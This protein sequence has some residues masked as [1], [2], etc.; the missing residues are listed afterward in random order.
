MWQHIEVDVRPR[1]GETARRHGL[2]LE[3]DV[4]AAVCSRVG[5]ARA[6]SMFGTLTLPELA[7]LL[8]RS[9]LLIGNDSGITHLAAA[10]GTPTVAL[11]GPQD[12]RRFRPWSD[13][14]IALR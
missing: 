5:K 14:A 7:A 11:F 10:C 9:S 2:A 3:R 1:G 4:E 8:T 13:R 12:P 6:L